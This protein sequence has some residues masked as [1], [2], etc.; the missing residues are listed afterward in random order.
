[1]YPW[2]GL[3]CSAAR[4]RR[5]AL[6]GQRGRDSDEENKDIFDRL[7]ASNIRVRD[8]DRR[9]LSP[10]APK[11]VLDGLRE[12]PCPGCQVIERHSLGSQS[13]R[14][15]LP[16]NPSAAVGWLHPRLRPQASHP[17]EVWLG[18]GRRQR[19]PDLHHAVPA[20]ARWPGREPGG[21]AVGYAQRAR[22]RDPSD[23]T[24]S[25]R[26]R[27]EFFVKLV[28]AQVAGIAE[29]TDLIARQRHTPA[30]ALPSG[31]QGPRPGGR[32]GRRRW[33]RTAPRG[34]ERC[35]TCRRT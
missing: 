28:L 32:E 27:D 31:P 8:G 29:P 9:A 2:L 30:A 26:L 15:A 33:H 1:M 5:R 13:A 21:G 14:A 18:V 3:R 35:S 6:C 25:P 7:V 16:P 23:S 10:I 12:R 4:L 17:P 11:S 22:V 24:G 34:G 20:G 19:R